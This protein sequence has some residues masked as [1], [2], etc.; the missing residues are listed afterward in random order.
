MKIFLDSK[1][2][3]FNSNSTILF[4]CD[5]LKKSIPRFC[6]HQKLSIAG[7]C[8]MCLVQVEESIKPVASCAAF[9]SSNLRIFTNSF[10]VKKARESV[11]EFLLINH[12]LDCPICDQ[13]GEC[14]LQDQT[15]LYGGDR[16][17]FFEQKRAV[18]NIEFN[19]IIKT[20]MTR[21]IH[22]TRCVRFSSE[23]LG[24]NNL[25]LIGRGNN[26]RISTFVEKA[27]YSELS[28]NLADICP[29]GA[30]TIKPYSFIARPWE[31]KSFNTVDVFDSHSNGLKFDV[32]GNDIL[33]V[34]PLILSAT[35][36]EWIS[37]V[38]RFFF[39][40]LKIQRLTI[41]GVFNKV[42]TNFQKLSWS[43]TFFLIKSILSKFSLNDLFS[44]KNVSFKFGT[45]TEI[46]IFDVYKSIFLFGN[47]QKKFLIGNFY[48]KKNYNF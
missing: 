8:R 18:K 27:V 19:N 30:L 37:D 26:V 17:R 33:R 5:L 1:T 11:I 21:C 45:L 24:L 4:F 41:P 3:E 39:D 2:I 16:G 14:D 35:N 47:I 10:L 28:G 12:P 13:G 40:S 36:Q 46:D 20:F 44:K 22:C 48:Q 42:S 32:R 25:G 29:V 43:Q 31:L 7:N 38:S 34:T 9:T 23:I 15:I 6:Y